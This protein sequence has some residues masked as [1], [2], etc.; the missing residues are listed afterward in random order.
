MQNVAIVTRS[1]YANVALRDRS[2]AATA[3]VITTS[4]LPDG[5]VGAAYSQVIQ[6][7]GTEPITAAVQSGSLPTGLSLNASTRVLSGAPTTPVL[8]S[9]TVRATNSA[10][11]DD[12]ALTLLVPNEG[13][14][15]T[16]P[17]VTTVTLV[18]VSTTVEAGGTVDLIATVEDELGNPIANVVGSVEST[19]SG[20]AT[21]SWLAPTDSNGAAT[22]RVTGVAA[23]GGV[24][25][26]YANI[27][28][29]VDGVR[30]NA[31]AV[32]ITAPA[33]G[34]VTGVSV[35]PATASVA[36]SQQ[37]Q[38]SA[39]VSGTGPFS[40]AV[41]WSVQSGGGLVSA[42]G[43]YTAPASPTTAVV[44][45][46]AAANSSIYG[47][48]TIVV[49]AESV[50]DAVVP[51]AMRISEWEGGARDVRVRVTVS[52][53]SPAGVVVAATSSD[54]TRVSIAA[55]AVANAQGVATFPVQFLIGGR[56]VLTFTSGPDSVEMLAVV[57]VLG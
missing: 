35:S 45:A 20:N 34:T 48:A 17:V 12:Q 37:Q 44:R 41:V 10:G 24:S 33:S 57:R 38:F 16:G 54:S 21:G 28:A 31:C 55:S 5:A 40:T 19:S 2:P 11:Y 51:S 22:I 18:P 7:T 49:T 36:V 46:A 32:T 27:S 50:V 42:S 13:S 26:G 1:T 6:A 53:G 47:E 52:A 56:S 15:G 3:P 8:V 4:A 30:S 43:M 14:G 39:N 23:G 25:N 29:I 9:F